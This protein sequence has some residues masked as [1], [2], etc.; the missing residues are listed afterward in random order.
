MTWYI[1]C[2][3]VEKMSENSDYILPF[4][5]EN[6]DVRGRGAYLNNLMGDILEHHNY[7]EQVERILGECVALATML[8]SNMKY[9]G[10]MILQ[11]QTSG[12]V[13]LCV[14]DITLPD[15]VRALAKYDDARLNKAIKAGYVSTSALMGRGHLALTIDQGEY[16]ER[17]QGVVE[18][19][20]QG[21]ERAAFQY[22]N[23]SEQIPTQVRLSSIKHD[24]KW[25]A[26][27][28]MIQHLPKNSTDHRD[29]DGG[30]NPNGLTDEQIVDNNWTEAKTL[31]ATVEDA[32]LTDKEVTP[33]KLA[34][35]LYH[36]NDVQ[37]FQRHHFKA[38]CTCSRERLQKLVAQF[39][40]EE[41][42][43][44]SENGKVTLNCDYCGRNYEF[45][46]EEIEE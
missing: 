15:K 32:E 38:E 30:D 24:G 41:K 13:R 2:K 10:R 35:R 20:G 11:T 12:A 22:F 19:G 46:A 29:L 42:A 33:E 44:V 6:L 23:Q 26:S 28:F 4:T 3:K 39:S 18:L 43:D 45:K 36:E 17:Y 1:N 5:V 8:A 27:G 34:F 25:H 31:L 9:E 37:M 40:R 7:P 16:T 21:L 14:V